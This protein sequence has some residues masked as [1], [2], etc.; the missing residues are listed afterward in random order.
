M[1]FV[2]VFLTSIVVGLFTIKIAHKKNIFIDHHCSSKPQ[3]VH[4]LPT[5]RAGGIAIFIASLAVLSTPLGI[6]LL[7]PMLLAFAS[8]L[9][10]DYANAVSQ[11]TRLIIQSAAA[12]L[13]IFTT[14]IYIKTIGLGIIFPYPVAILFTVFAIVGVINAI[15]IIDGLNGLAGGVSISALIAFGALS[16]ILNDVEMF[17]ICLI[18]FAAILGFL[19]LN[20]PI[21]KIFLGDGGA[22][23]IGFM[24]AIISIMITH[25]HP[26]VS[27]WFCASVLA[28]PIWEVLFSVLRRRQAK[29]KDSMEADKMHLH[30][31]IMRGLSLSN[32]R[33]ALLIVVCF[34]PFQLISLFFYDKGYVLFGIIIVFV[35]LYN[36]SY[37]YLVKAAF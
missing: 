2:I 5:P 15:N 20:F 23:F 21:A 37:R 3:R 25:K 22:Y 32:P 28:Y 29:G 7:P 6:W 8:G 4:D 31:L 34:L 27:A 18:F 11:K 24:M 35:L 13:F 12:L 9:I 10:E 16:Y 26:E 30:H 17:L 14:G 36:V 33:T 19:I 1:V